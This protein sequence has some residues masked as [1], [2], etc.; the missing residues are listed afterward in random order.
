MIILIYFIKESP[1]GNKRTRES[2][3]ADDDE[4]NELFVQN[5]GQLSEESLSS[6]FTKYGNVQKVKIAMDRNTNRPRGFAFVTFE[7][8][9]EARLAVSEGNEAEVSNLGAC[10]LVLVVRLYH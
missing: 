2:E 6:Y 10:R 9:A 4:S 7:T 3:D 8:V 5:V 1:N